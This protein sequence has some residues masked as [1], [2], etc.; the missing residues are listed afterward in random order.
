[1]KSALAN[2]QTLPLKDALALNW[3]RLY[4]SRLCLLPDE[5]TGSRMK[6]ECSRMKGSPVL[7]NGSMRS[8]QSGEGE[9]H[10]ALRN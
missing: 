9:I 4:G 3:A 8:N 1:M 7:A 2:F 5:N 10:R 6:A